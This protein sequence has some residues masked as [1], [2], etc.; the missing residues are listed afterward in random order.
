MSASFRATAAGAFA[1]D[2]VSVDQ[3]TTTQVGDML[4]AVATGKPH[5]SDWSM[6]SPWQSLG[7]GTSG[8]TANGADVGS[9]AIEAWWMEADTAGIVAHTLTEDSAGW[10]VVAFKIFV[11]SKEVGE[12]WETPVAV[13][14]S[15]V[16]DGTAIAITFDS[17]PGLKPGDGVMV[18]AGMNTDALGPLTSNLTPAATGVSA[19]SSITERAE[20]ESTTGNDM[21]FHA[22]TG[23]VL[24]GRSTAAPTCTGT[25]TA[26]GTADEVAAALIRLRTNGIHFVASVTPDSTTNG[27]NA[28]LTMPS[29]SCEGDFIIAA[30]GDSLQGESANFDDS[31]VENGWTKLGRLYSSETGDANLAVWGRFFRAD[32]AATTPPITV[33]G[34]NNASAATVGVAQ[35]FRGVDPTRPLAVVPT[36]ATG[37]DTRSANPAAIT[38]G[39]AGAWVVIV[40][41]AGTETGGSTLTY[42]FPTGYTTNATQIAGNDTWD[43][44][45]G[46]G[47][48]AEAGAGA[49]DPGVMT[50][51]SDSAGGGWAAMT[52]AL[53]PVTESGVYLVHKDWKAAAN[54]ADMTFTLPT[55]LEGDLVL[56]ATA[57]PSDTDQN[58][59]MDTADYTEVTDLYATDTD[60]T[61]LGVFYK[62]MGGSPDATA[63]VNGSAI[64]G[65][66]GSAVLMVFRTV[67]DSSPM[68]ATATTATGTNSMQADPPSIDYS[69]TDGL[70][71]IVGACGHRLATGGGY[72]FPQYYFGDAAIS[73][74]T[75]DSTVAMAIKPA[76]L[77][78]DPEN[79][80]KFTSVGTTAG[81]VPV[82]EVANSSWAAV[83]MVLRE[84]VVVGGGGGFISVHLIGI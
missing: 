61:N 56:V 77:A 66:G 45:I 40:G 18:T 43:C 65:N 26:S 31:I 59:S 55:L 51:S 50:I 53:R 38:P 28:T 10:D 68:D 70:V 20:S 42:T 11:F 79:P 75:L 6:A 21:A 44:I 67:D 64:V 15:D 82:A 46:M 27:G 54:G 1:V 4:I 49:E 63:V 25:A 52:I 39:V 47:Y 14:G 7:R 36:T 58:M 23:R 60:D 71:V 80:G 62:V 74:D 5:D 9:V 83:T 8:T 22:T 48:K 69:D 37:I 19:W 41:E 17:D 72:V 13:F 35:I 34:S 3:D 12:T 81:S 30:G 2:S 78:S 57:Q 33:V 24:A 73:N 76:Y 84:L 32:E 29:G 16:V